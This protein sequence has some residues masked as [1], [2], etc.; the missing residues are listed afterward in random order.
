M[1]N[2]L[3]NLI[4]PAYRALDIVSRELAGFI[5]AVNIDAAADTIAKGQTVYS[6]VTPT[7]ENVTDIA[8]AMTVTAA[9]DHTFATKDLIIDNYKETGFNW[10]AEEEFG[11]NTGI[12][13]E[14]LM[15]NTL[16]Q[17]F[18]KHINAIELSLATK[19]KN[20]AS[21]AWV[22]AA[23]TPPVFSDYAQAKK[24]LDDN[25]A[26]LSDRSAVFDTTAGVALRSTANLYKVNEAGSDALVRAGILG[27]LYG[28]ALRESAQVQTATAGTM[29][30]AVTSGALPAGTTAITYS[31][32]TAGATGFVAGDIVT[33][34]SHKYVVAVGA[35]AAAG[36]ITINAPGLVV[37]AAGAA[38]IA[39][40]ATTTRNVAMSRDAITLATRLPK[41]QAGDLASDRQVVTDPYTGISFELAMW[42]GSRM[43]KYTIAIAYGS[44]VANPEHLAIIGG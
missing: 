7:G 17:E 18:R 14:T 34:G 6:P 32:G 1:A 9:A 16:A 41:F 42:P 28:F 33:I 5:S 44:V 8:P 2:T 37:G 39:V 21:R 13:M 4:P 43:V 38:P 19:A 35:T 27:N 40:V 10:Q 20:G 31:G 36:T 29:T 23:G 24:I 30:T 22:T 11:I 3:T 26:P 25:G 12:G 15:V